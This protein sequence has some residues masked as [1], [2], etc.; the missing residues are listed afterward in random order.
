MRKLEIVSFA[1]FVLMHLMGVGSLLPIPTLL[2]RK[3]LQTKRKTTHFLILFQ[4]VL[5]NVVANL[6]YLKIKILP[7]KFNANF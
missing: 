3:D 6:V 4:F 2:I 7:R 5:I 1:H